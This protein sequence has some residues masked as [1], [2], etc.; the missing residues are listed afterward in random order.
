M[1]LYRGWNLIYL[2]TTV[3]LLAVVSFFAIKSNLK[4]NSEI[5]GLKDENY[6]LLETIEKRDHIIAGI[7]EV[8]R[9]TTEKKKSIRKGTDTDNFNNSLDV[10][11]KLSGT[12]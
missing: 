2:I 7:Q 10:L 11:S 3:L 6:G 5:S 4:K 12:D 8:N 9:E 1:A